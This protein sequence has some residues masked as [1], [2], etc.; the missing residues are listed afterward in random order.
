MKW[1]PAVLSALLLGLLLPG[2]QLQALETDT[3]HVTDLTGHLPPERQQVLTRQA[4]DQLD[5]ILRFYGEPPGTGQMGKIHLEFDQPRNGIYA[6]VFLMQR[7]GNRKV[8]VVRVFGAEKPP[9]QLAHKLTHA[10]F[11]SPDKLIRN[12]MGIPMEM[13]YGNPLSFPMCGYQAEEWVA[14]FRRQ[15]AYIPLAELGPDHEQWG[16]TTE[17]GVPVTR[18]R[19]RQHIMYAESAAFGDYLLQT[20][21]AAKMKRFWE[22][23]SGGQRSWTEAFGASLPQLEAAWLQAMDAKPADKQRISYLQGLFDQ[24]PP[25]ACTVAQRQAWQGR[26]GR[27]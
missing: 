7:Q 8:R 9:Q 17:N 4:Q 21:G 5:R 2:L 11:I 20:H 15:G 10:S 16:M 14:A 19:P 27:R 1:Y 6:T 24:N 25:Q 26:R 18:N 22:L 23:S 13:R 3:F 12:M